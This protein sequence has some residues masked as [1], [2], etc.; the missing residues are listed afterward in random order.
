MDSA[1][2]PHHLEPATHSAVERLQP[3]GEFIP[4]GP[5]KGLQGR[6]RFIHGEG[7]AVSAVGTPTRPHG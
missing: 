6:A 7:L 2:F 3:G 4:R 5:P 1:L